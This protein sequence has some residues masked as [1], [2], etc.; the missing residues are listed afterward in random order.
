MI[1]AE[2]DAGVGRV[3]F[4]LGCGGLG[5]G[6]E[7]EDEYRGDGGSDECFHKNPPVGTCQFG[8]GSV[9]AMSTAAVMHGAKKN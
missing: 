2:I 5:L 3:Y 4:P 6:C 7:N 1:D 8:T 9:L